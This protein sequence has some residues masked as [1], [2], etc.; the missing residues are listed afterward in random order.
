MSGVGN[1]SDL[2]QFVLNQLHA[3]TADFPDRPEGEWI[4]VR[5]RIDWRHRK[6][7]V[8]DGIATAWTRDKVRVTVLGQAHP[9]RPVW[10]DPSNVKR[11]ED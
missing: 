1:P 5:V 9:M 11:R 10:L 8:E 6:P 3:P 7:T 4:P 2:S